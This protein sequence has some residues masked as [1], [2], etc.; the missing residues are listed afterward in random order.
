MAE[1]IVSGLNAIA[2]KKS[3]TDI[4]TIDAMPAFNNIGYGEVRVPS[5]YGMVALLAETDYH[6]N[7]VTGSYIINNTDKIARAYA[8]AIVKTFNIS[9][10]KV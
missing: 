10:N 7:S 2:P 3:S 4:Q 5:N 8:E 9:K 1:N 6:D